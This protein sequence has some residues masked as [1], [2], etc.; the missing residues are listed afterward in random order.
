MKDEQNQKVFRIALALSIG[1]SLIYL[2]FLKPGIWG[3]D[4]NDMLYVSQ[5]LVTDHDFTV[6]PSAGVLGRNGEYYSIRYPL[7]PIIATPFVAI[8]LALGEWLHLPT[9]YTSAVCALVLPIILTAITASLVAL[10]ALRL[11]STEKG[12]YLAALSFAFGTIA[13]VYSREFFAEPLLSLI[14]I[15]SLYLTLGKT[16]REHAGASILSGIIITAKPSGIVVGPVLSAYLL[17]KKYPLRNAI[18]PLLG[19]GMGVLM[20]LAYN[21]MRFGDFFSGGQNTSRLQLEG[22]PERLVGLIFS[23]G[24]GGGLLWY[25]PPVILGIIGFRKLFKNKPLEALAIVGIFSGYWVLHSFWRF[26]GWNWGPRFLM[27]TLPLL[28]ALTALIGQKWWKWFI[29]L[30][31]LGFFWNAPSLIAYYQ[32][33]YAEAADKGYL[34]KALALWGSPAD[35]PLFN[36]WGAA[37]RQLGNAL[38]TSTTDLITQIGSPPARGELAN[39]EL[40][41]IVAVWWWVLPAA[42]IP[43]WIGFILAILLLLIGVWILRQGWLMV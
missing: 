18:G 42:G 25:C 21:Y 15:W 30:T 29:G 11:G 28:L 38:T 37:L 10:L 12:A 2:A 26:G 13:L 27:P 5:S 17:A 9:H 8:G 23:P 43:M 4:G 7:L 35:A 36:A 40:L 3:F 39:A 33:Y 24:A 20:Y 31:L 14:T 1:I 22:M 6:P 41:K 34:A 16:S 32:G 19:T